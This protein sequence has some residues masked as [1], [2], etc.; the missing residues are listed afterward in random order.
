MLKE[1]K[2]IGTG[3]DKFLEFI[4]P[5]MKYKL[6]EFMY[7]QQLGTFQIFEQCEPCEIMYIA[8]L[9]KPKLNIVDEEII[10]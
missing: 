7:C 6:I 10:T 4:N 1:K 5:G 2:E 9:M 8:M 3:V